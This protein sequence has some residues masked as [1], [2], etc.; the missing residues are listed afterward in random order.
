MSAL[1]AALR[2]LPLT[3]F[4]YVVEAMLALY[5]ALPWSLEVG[6]DAR[7]SLSSAIGRAVWLDR[8]G[9]L[10]PAV[11]VAGRSGLLSLGLVLLLSP[12]LQMAWLSSMQQSVSAAAALEQGVRLYLRAVGVSL[13]SLLVAALLVVPWAGAAW[14]AHALLAAPTRA[15]LHDCALVVLLSPCCLALVYAHVMHDLARARALSAGAFA[16]VAFGL[17]SALRARVLLAAL[18]LLLASLA[19]RALQLYASQHHAG[20]GA[21]LNVAVLQGACLGA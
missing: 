14:L 3:F 7:A 6:A 18:A 9:E 5:C 11:R 1:P 12:W 8:V 16:A 15:R 2:A 20:V 17:R 21:L 13:L 19:L 10:L 4:V